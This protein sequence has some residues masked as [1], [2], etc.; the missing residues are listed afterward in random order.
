M[1]P[2][3]T[4]GQAVMLTVVCWNCRRSLTPEQAA[5]LLARQ[6]V[7]AFL[8][9]EVGDM[10]ECG[11]ALIA[12][13]G[14][15][16]CR[17]TRGEAM[18]G[19]GVAIALRES[20][21]GDGVADFKQMGS[22]DAEGYPSWELVGLHMPHLDLTLASLYA[23]P[24]GSLDWPPLFQE[25]MDKK[26]HRV[27]LAGDFNARHPMWD[28]RVTKAEARI[29]A[30][31]LLTTSRAFGYSVLVPPAPTRPVS[32]TSPDV[33]LVRG[34]LGVRMRILPDASSDHA[35]IH[36]QFPWIG[37]RPL[38]RSGEPRWH[39]CWRKVTKGQ[40]TLFRQRVSAMV[41]KNRAPGT[42][43]YR[44]GCAITA[45]A[46]DIL[47]GG[48]GRR[49]GGLPRSVKKLI[50][51]GHAAQAATAW[52]TYV[53]SLPLWTRVR[54]LEGVAR[55]PGTWDTVRA[56]LLP[57]TPT[58]ERMRL[59]LD[60]H[61]TSV[62]DTPPVQGTCD[63]SRMPAA[64]VTVREIRE[65]LRAAPRKRKADPWGLSPE[66]WRQCDD[67][68]LSWVAE[69]CTEIFVTGLMPVAFELLFRGPV[70]KPSGGNR[71]VDVTLAISMMFERICLAR[72]ATT[73]G[74]R[75]DPDVVSGGQFAFTRGLDTSYA[76]GRV[77]AA[78]Q[79]VFG[80][81][82]RSFQTAGI[83]GRQENMQPRLGAV[84][85][86]YQSAFPSVSHEAI[87]AAVDRSC[88]VPYLRRAI[89]ALMVGWDRTGLKIRLRSPRGKVELI[90][91][92]VGFAAGRGLCPLIWRWLVSEC[93]PRSNEAIQKAMNG[94]QGSTGAILITQLVADDITI[95][96]EG[97]VP[98]EIGDA[99]RKGVECWDDWGKSNGLMLSA[100]KCHFSAFSQ[101]QHGHIVDK[102]EFALSRPQNEGFVRDREQREQRERIR[103][104]CVKKQSIHLYGLP[105]DC[106]LNMTEL[107]AGVVLNYRKAAARVLRVR[108]FLTAP[109]ALMVG[110]AWA[111]LPVAIAWWG[112]L[113]KRSVMQKIDKARAQVAREILNVHDSAGTEAVLLECGWGGIEKVATS[114]ARSAF[115]RLSAMT[116]KI[117][118]TDMMKS[119]LAER[120]QPAAVAAVEHAPPPLEQAAPTRVQVARPA[121]RATTTSTTRKRAVSAQSS[122][123][124]STSSSQAT[125]MQYFRPRSQS[126][127]EEVGGTLLDSSGPAT[128]EPLDAAP[129]DPPGPATA[130]P[131][132]LLDR[133]WG[134]RMRQSTQADVTFTGLEGDVGVNKSSSVDERRAFNEARMRDARVTLHPNPF[135]EVWS[136]ATVQHNGSAW[137]CCIWTREDV[138]PTTTLTGPAGTEACSFSGEARAIL[139]GLRH[140]V[141]LRGKAVHARPVR[142]LWFTDSLSC[143]SMLEKG[144]TNQR[145]V[146]GVLIWKELAQLEG[147]C[148]VRFIF[149]FS[150]SGTP[151][152]ESVDKAAAAAVQKRAPPEGVWEQD[153]LRTYTKSMP[154]I[155]SVTRSRLM[156][157]PEGQSR[158]KL[159]P[160]K[161]LVLSYQEA[162]VVLPG[163]VG[164]LGRGNLG[165]LQDA[166]DDCLWCRT[167]GCLGREG[168][169][170]VHL[171]ACV[172]FRREHPHTC[173]PIALWSHPRE[174]AAVMIAFLE[175]WG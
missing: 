69:I 116:P 23:R 96:V 133:F 3:L 9:Q 99:L 65:A 67:T 140:I 20:W 37:V 13:S 1:V 46:R 143:V 59:A 118:G 89:Q 119:F 55:V 109:E 53:R 157:T 117:E 139:C 87:L 137:A 126:L 147:W 98:K 173:E 17:N 36:M 29:R 88:A 68:V 158:P 149:V 91:M 22:P 54:L 111:S 168:T 5:L 2:L 42:E 93:I 28:A 101:A 138:G 70:P 102:L 16:V 161:K 30:E 103:A 38:R 76:V 78:A 106:R 144:A 27:M 85:L 32:G 160:L 163:R 165:L 129:L 75:H 142:I 64:P 50:H 72:I 152:N 18:K 14:F 100:T 131:P 114:R 94:R 31:S 62:G 105:L 41:R 115:L 61:K 24:G 107:V 56:E 26:Y 141:S 4:K 6:E 10:S 60:R 80:K 8:L 51:Q 156:Q 150:H 159:V 83:D 39:V 90:Q 120:L 134:D 124:A 148:S 57:K 21:V 82:Q 132:K 162:A 47:P 40:M 33:V 135:W 43:L 11:I 170:I 125:L 122:A 71:P 169:A 19:G 174:A 45:A 127:V 130:V 108:S 121:L 166:P 77:V 81:V 84:I 12:S 92:W 145:D 44:I 171:F 25:F 172:G 112:P 167:P 15:V 52:K 110:Q 7:D 66:L 97:F 48:W 74:V 153:A 49:L 34:V 113:L 35:M 175:K 155:S 128:A 79:S 63:D 146:W 73:H 136:D 154:D 58:E 95:L 164:L 104:L 123:P 86:D 151:R